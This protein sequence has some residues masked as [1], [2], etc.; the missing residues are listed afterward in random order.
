LADSTRTPAGTNS[1]Y[2]GASIC[3]PARSWI[4]DR[5]FAVFALITFFLAL[6]PLQSGAALAAHMTWQGFTPATYGAVMAV[7]GLLIIAFQP[8]L[9]RALMRLGETLPLFRGFSDQINEDVEAL[10]EAATFLSRRKIGAVIAI[11]RDT[12]LGTID[13]AKLNPKGSSVAVGHPFAAT[14]ARIVATL[15]QQ[16]AQRGSGRGLLSICTAGGMGVTAILER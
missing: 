11:E 12:P 14:G 15:A 10:V 2:F 7:N 3:P 1:G 5:E 13:R 16:L 6:L 4:H 8:E 9:R